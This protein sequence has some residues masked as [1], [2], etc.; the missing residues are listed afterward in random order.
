MKV[1]QEESHYVNAEDTHDHLD[2]I[3]KKYEIDFRKKEVVWTKNEI[4][5][6]DYGL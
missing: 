3:S 6:L 1:P 5:K 2:A 4:R